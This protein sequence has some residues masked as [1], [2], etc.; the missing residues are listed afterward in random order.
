V[1]RRARQLVIALLCLLAAQ[2]LIGMTANLYARIPPA[3]PQVRGNLDT[4]LGLA[5]RWALLH[6][7]LEIKLH[8]ALGLAIGALP[9]A[10]SA[11]LAG[12][13]APPSP[14]GAPSDRAVETERFNPAA[15]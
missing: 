8:V 11:R 4:R 5:A 1:K 12:H 13:A 14:P 6:G 2:F 3:L 15:R 9:T 10:P 7:P